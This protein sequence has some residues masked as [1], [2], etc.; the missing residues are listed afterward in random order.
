MSQ[1]LMI[2]ENFLVLQ[3]LQDFKRLF[4]LPGLETIF[5]STKPNILL[6]PS[7]YDEDCKEFAVPIS[8]I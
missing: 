1:K 8:V 4:F 6:Y 5:S 2:K 3:K 7:Y